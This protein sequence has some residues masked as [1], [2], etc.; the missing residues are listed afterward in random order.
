MFEVFVDGNGLVK[1]AKCLYMTMRLLK[2]QS[3][4]R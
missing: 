2:W 4:C 1:V 3:V